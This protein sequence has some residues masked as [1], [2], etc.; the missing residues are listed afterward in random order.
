M[1]APPSR[2]GDER[3]AFAQRTAEY[4]L[5]ILTQW[6]DPADSERHIEWTRGFA[7]AM[8]PFR[9]GAYLLNFLGEE[10]EDTI[11]AA[12]GAELR[13]AGRGEEQVRP[14]QLL[15]GQPEHRAS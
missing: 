13:A 5:G 9:S 1:A 4:D 6:A 8:A 15:P 3:T 7:D 2:V 14:D 10:G 12:F 11:R